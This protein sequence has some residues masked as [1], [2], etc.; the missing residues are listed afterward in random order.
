MLLSSRAQQGTH[1]STQGIAGLAVR[2]E[3]DQVDLSSSSV[4]QD[5][6][7]Q[8]EEILNLPDLHARA[9]ADDETASLFAKAGIAQADLISEECPSH[10]ELKSLQCQLASGNI[11]HIAIQMVS[12][13]MLV[14]PFAE[15]LE[16]T[17]RDVRPDVGAS[18]EPGEAFGLLYT[19]HGE[20][21]CP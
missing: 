10:E 3:A 7:T 18:I 15:G 5:G 12:R 11:R 6:Q 8:R 16:V 1:R 9:R 13:L 20:S 2:S 17:V 14:G 4:M 19:S 21:D